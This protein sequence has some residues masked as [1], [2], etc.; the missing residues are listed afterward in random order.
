MWDVE[1]R[2][3]L[4]LFAGFAT[5]NQRHCHT[6][7]ISMVH[8]QVGTSK[9]HHKTRAIWR[10]LLY[11]VTEKLTTTFEFNKVLLI[12]FSF[13]YLFYLFIIY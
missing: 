6:K 7:I 2:K 8:D 3:Y 9:L 13:T 10:N 4:D 12:N 1:D 5:I 11:E